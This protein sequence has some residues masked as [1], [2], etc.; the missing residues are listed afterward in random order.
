M[1]RQS[2]PAMPCRICASV[3][4]GLRSSNALA[5][6]ICPFWQNPHWG[7]CSSIH[8]CCSGCSLPS[9]ARPSRVV[10]CPLTADTGRMHDR[11][12]LPLRIT[13]Q[14]PHC[15]SP[16][17]NR[18]P[19]SPRS[20]RR[21][22]S[23]G[24]EGSTSSVWDLPLTFNEM[25]LIVRDS[26]A[27]DERVPQWQFMTERLY[28]TDSYLREF[29]ARVVDLS[30]DRRTVYLDRTA[31]YPTSGGQPFDTG[32]IA[33]KRVVEVVDE[34]S[35]IAHRL[36]EPVADVEVHCTVDWPRRFDHMQQH[37]GQHLLS[38]VF[39]EMFGL[40]TVSFHLGAESATIDLEGMPVDNRIAT[41]VERR[42]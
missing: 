37:T 15:P 20:F 11:V 25:L 26:I 3:A 18:G 12:A 16:Q 5:V 38:A 1:Q 39:E 31:F 9:L 21:M 40:K 36:A 4:F 13:V 8:A 19:C 17:P 34:D 33:G 7:A 23:S 14:A 30:S 22:Y 27:I 6:M 28:Y 29:D 10:I 41:D 42:A 35:R 2:V 32:A 24:V